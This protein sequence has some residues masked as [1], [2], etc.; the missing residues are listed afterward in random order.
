MSDPA[1]QRVR[2]VVF[3]RPGPNWN[4]GVDFREQEGLEN[5]CSII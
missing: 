1:M 2:H 4:P 3:H 5:M